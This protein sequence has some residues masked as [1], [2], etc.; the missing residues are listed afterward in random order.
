MSENNNY[1][2]NNFES[3]QIGLASTEKILE[4]SHGEVTKPETINY[5]TLK[6]EKEGLFCERIFGPQK[7]WECHCGKYKRIRYKGI[8][9]DRCGV[10]VTK[11]KVRRERMG[12]I[13]LAAPVSHIWYFKG[14]PS[15]M[16]LVLDISPRNLEKVL[17]FAAYIVLDPGTTE[18]AYKEVLT[19]QQYREAK[20]KFGNEFKAAMGAEAVRELLTH[21]DLGE[22]SEELRGKL[23]DATGQKKIRIVRRLEVIEA[24]RASGNKPE[25]MIL[26]VI[27]VIPPDLRPMV[28][29]EDSIET[30]LLNL[31]R[32]TGIDG[33]TGIAPRNGHVV[34]PLLSV[35]RRDIEEWLSEQGEG[36][37]TDSTNLVNDVKRNKVRLDVIPLLQT[38]NP[39]VVDSIYQTSLRLTEAARMANSPV[40]HDRYQGDT[41]PFAMLRSE[42]S[43]EY[44]LWHRLA[45]L[46]FTPAQVEDM[47]AAIDVR[48]GMEWQSSTHI[49]VTSRDALVIAPL[50][51]QAP[52]PVVMPEAGT[53]HIS[54]GE[55]LKV[56]LA[57]YTPDMPISRDPLSVMLDATAVELPLTLR[58]VRQGDRFTPLGMRGSKLVS[59]YLTDRKRNLIEKRRQLVVTDARDRVVWLVGERPDHRCR[60]TADTRRYI[61]LTYIRP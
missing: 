34:R 57:P 1:E 35:S 40:I 61:Q 58:R 9:C 22:L 3:L 2:L 25:W 36:Y 26:E 50:E 60:I 38:I 18:F 20:E 54:S 27:P 32:G 30:V 52:Q 17:Y 46:G 48:P 15:R 51:P 45:P 33:L 55:R 37:V 39:S 10:E 41:L 24:L 44:V 59:D 14:I 11:A 31:I 13:K 47:A 53:Y 8:V 56:E 28:H 16:G 49:V 43:A 42:A 4:W 23:K 29:R 7:D 5:R 21:I 12:H 6:P 19:E